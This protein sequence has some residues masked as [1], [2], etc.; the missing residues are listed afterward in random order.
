MS[1]R[2]ADA[3]TVLRELVE[4][5]DE[6]AEANEREPLSDPANLQAYNEAEA[7]FDAAISAARSHLYDTRP[8]DTIPRERVEA[9]VREAFV[10]GYG[11]GVDD[12]FDESASWEQSDARAALATTRTE[13]GGDE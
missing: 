8:P 7:R 10:E 1:E 12:H 11:F 5:L 9:L 13:G 6:M 2:E 4:A 3:W